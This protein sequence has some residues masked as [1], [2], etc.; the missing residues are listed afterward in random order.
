M[1]LHLEWQIPTSTLYA[2]DYRQASG[3]DCGH[4]HGYEPM[5]PETT[6][7]RF[8]SREITISIMRTAIRWS[9]NIKISTS[10][11]SYSHKHDRPSLIWAMQLYDAM[12]ISSEIGRGKSRS[13]ARSTFVR[14]ARDIL[15]L[16][17][18]TIH[19]DCSAYFKNECKQLRHCQLHN[20]R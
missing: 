20:S 14:S 7:C 10:I 9:R 19:S 13:R 6:S 11:S 4:F 17:I 8:R 1:K 12:R 18:S 15:D 2:C 5:R 3:N 16:S